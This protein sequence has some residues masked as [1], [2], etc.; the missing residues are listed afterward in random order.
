MTE[1]SQMQEPLQK[2]PDQERQR[3]VTPGG[4]TKHAQ[5]FQRGAGLTFIN[6]VP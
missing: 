1:V 3:L 2:P 4:N 5:S 6:R